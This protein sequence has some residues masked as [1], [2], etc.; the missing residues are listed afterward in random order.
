MSPL[1][2][3]NSYFNIILHL[4]VG[5]LS[6]LFPSGSPAQPCTHL[7]CFPLVPL[8]LSL[9]SLWFVT[10][11]FDTVWFNLLTENTHTHTHTHTHT[12]TPIDRRVSAKNNHQRYLHMQNR[13]FHISTRDVRFS[14]Q[15]CWR[16][17]SCEKDVLLSSSAWS[18]PNRD[19]P[20]TTSSWKRKHYK[21]SNRQ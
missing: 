17:K 14:R 2:F 4:R 13:K 6:G 20:W 8:A 5:S 21:P 16:S 15:C 3:L 11:R 1:H 7:S 9:S 18:S 19:P 12:V 10:L